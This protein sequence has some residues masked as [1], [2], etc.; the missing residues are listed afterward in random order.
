MTTRTVG[1]DMNKRTPAAI[2]YHAEKIL[3]ATILDGWNAPY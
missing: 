2:E 3:Q 1:K